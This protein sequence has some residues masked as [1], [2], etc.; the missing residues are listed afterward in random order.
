M[1]HN[2]GISP[3]QGR[4]LYV[5]GWYQGGIDVM[6]FSDADHPSE[7]AYSDRGSIDAPSD[8]SEAT[9]RSHYTI[10]GSWGA[11]YWNGMIYSS[12]LDRGFD[13]YEP[14]PNAQHAANEIAAAKPMT[15]TETTRRG[16]GGRRRFPWCARTS[17]SWCAA[18]GWRLNV[19]LRSRRH[20]TRLSGSAG[21]A[22]GAA[23]KAL[24]RQVEGYASGAR[25]GGRVR[26]MASEIKRLAAAQ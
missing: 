1:S 5:Q 16:S 21:G 20:S 15:L 22:R 19:P 9:E 7:I 17:T 14:T 8:T 26:V 6:D 3:V 4:D 18:M 13:V 23:L 12:E 24:A 10:S 25:D 2:G 11:Y